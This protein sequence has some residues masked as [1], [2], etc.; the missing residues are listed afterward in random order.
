MGSRSLP[1][2]EPKRV[3]THFFELSNI[4]RCSKQEEQAVEYVRTVAERSALQYRIDD[5]GNILVYKPT[6][7]VGSEP[8][9]FQS[10]LDMVC[11][12][13]RDTEHDFARDPI[14]LIEK[15]GNL[16]ADGTTL[17]ADN[18]IGVAYMLALMEATDIVHPPLEFLFTVD[19]EAGMT[20]AF[21]LDPS[22]VKARRLINL[23]TEEENYICTG[24]AGGGE[25]VLLLPLGEKGRSKRTKCFTLTVSHLQGGHSGFNMEL[26]RANAIRLLAQTLYRIS[27][28][29]ELEI[30]SIEGG[31]KINA[32]PREASATFFADD[33]AVVQRSVESIES[34][35]RTEFR[36]PDGALSIT[37]TE[38]EGETES[39]AFF[40]S[41]QLIRLLTALPYGVVTTSPDLGGA[42]ETTTNIG[43]VSI[44]NG[45][46]RIACLSRSYNNEK[47]ESVRDSICAIGA[48]CGA[49]MTRMGEYPAWTPDPTST[50]L[51]DLSAV[52]EA[53]SGKAPRIG[54]VHAGLETGIIGEKFER[55]DMVSLG[56]SIFYPHSPNEH[57]EIE[58]VARVWTVLCEL[59]S[60]L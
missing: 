45:A 10:H 51:R 20:G 31:N 58:S 59:L 26:G 33:I 50:L 52:Y 25:T 39:Y 24:C 44:E 8:L 18:G 14:R 48:L 16:H 22:L 55:F 35:F 41:M 37:V 7:K 12:K 38:E 13:N 27:L 56:P 17:G 1:A 46:A 4:P 9:A 3:W 28:T 54:A 47:I 40:P 2:L 6:T 57:V 53:V 32:I 15:N 29:I 43:T 42:V 34:S 11:E 5:C 21:G 19:E 49:T 36:N 30:G 60:R 23:D